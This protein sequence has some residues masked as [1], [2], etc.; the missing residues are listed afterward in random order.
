MGTSIRLLILILGVALTASC[1]G[2]LV[3]L[4][5]VNNVRQIDKPLSED[6]VK[7]SI[8]EGAANAGWQVEDLGF[9][10]IRATYQI[11]IHTVHVEIGYSDSFFRPYY[12]SSIAMKMRC[13]KRDKG[14]IVSGN[15]NCPGDQLPYSINANY[16]IWID[17]LV[18]SIESSL[19]TKKQN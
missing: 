4:H 15:K 7:E 19:A 18:A 3:A 13:S 6:Q 10:T 16:K 11:R 14:Y 8:L 5:D 12:K 17:S 1:S 2:G 9:H